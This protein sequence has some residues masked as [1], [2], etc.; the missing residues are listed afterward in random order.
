VTAVSAASLPEPGFGAAGEAAIALSAITV[1]TDP[2]HRVTSI[3]AANPLTENHFAI[4]RHARPQTGLDIGSRSW[5]VRNQLDA[6]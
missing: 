5:Q 1:L 2:E 4:N 3:A 6:W